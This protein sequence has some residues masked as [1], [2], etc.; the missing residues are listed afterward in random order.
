MRKKIKELLDAVKSEER[1]KLHRTSV[2]RAREQEKKEQAKR[3]RKAKVE[4]KEKAEEE[5]ELS[6]R[7]L[8]KA[9]RLKEIED[10]RSKNAWP[11]V[12]APIPVP[13][14]P[15]END[16]LSRKIRRRERRERTKGTDYSII[17]RE[18][19]RRLPNIVILTLESATLYK[20]LAF[21]VAMLPEAPQRVQVE[22]TELI[23]CVRIGREFARNIRRLCD[24][25]LLLY[26]R[27]PYEKQI[28]FLMSKVV[29]EAWG[30]SWPEAIDEHVKMLHETFSEDLERDIKWALQELRDKEELNL[31][32]ARDL[33]KRRFLERQELLIKRDQYEEAHKEQLQLFPIDT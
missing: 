10:E 19:F 2:E 29:K 24:F 7:E 20:D 4:L 15:E 33:R 27:L 12:A 9:A 3:A 31:L 5:K 18:G 13:P 23:E 17:P 28:N 1:P 14:T 30:N 25:I 21:S 11:E 16:R 22:A 32:K 6:R 26:K 8:R